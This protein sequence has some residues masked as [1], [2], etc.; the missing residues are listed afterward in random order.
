[1]TQADTPMPGEDPGALIED[2]PGEVDPVITADIEDDPQQPK[3][4]EKPTGHEAFDKARAESQQ[5][6]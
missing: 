3:V 1:M 6:K 4:V 5:R 2:V